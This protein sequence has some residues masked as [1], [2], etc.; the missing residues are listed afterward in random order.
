MGAPVLVEKDLAAALAEAVARRNEPDMT[1]ELVIIS[2][3]EKEIEDE[4]KN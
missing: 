3:G 4:A 1:G 2:P